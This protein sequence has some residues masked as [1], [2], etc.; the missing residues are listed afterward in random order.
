M[1]TG[2]SQGTVGG[3]CAQV[4]GRGGPTLVLPGRTWGGMSPGKCRAP[5]NQHSSRCPFQQHC[6]RSLR[7]LSAPSCRP[8]MSPVPWQPELHTGDTA[9]PQ[10]FPA[11]APRHR[12]IHGDIGAKTSSTST[13]TLPSQTEL[14]QAQHPWEQ[15]GL[16]GGLLGKAGGRC[17]CSQHLLCPMCSHAAP[18]SP[19]MAQHLPAPLPGTQAQIGQ[20]PAPVRWETSA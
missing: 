17:G 16:L 13:L 19:C 10:Q 4:K 9:G 20:D 12:G 15:P 6:R 2:T 8:A 11:P 3:G 14:E 18:G 7:T 5:Q 1:S